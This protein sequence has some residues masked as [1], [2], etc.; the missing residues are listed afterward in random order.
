MCIKTPR[1]LMHPC[2]AS[3]T[4]QRQRLCRCDT[5]HG[6]RV[7]HSLLAVANTVQWSGVSCPE[8]GRVLN[9][10]S[11]L[12]PMSFC[13]AAA[14]PLVIDPRLG[15]ESFRWSGRVGC[16]RCKAAEW[17]WSALV[18]E[19]HRIRTVGGKR[20]TQLLHLPARAPGLEMRD[21]R[22]TLQLP[23]CASEL[24][25]YNFVKRAIFRSG[26]VIASWLDTQAEQVGKARVSSLR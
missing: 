13:Q 3:L 25:S 20:R 24:L 4:L 2:F 14:A 18:G 23:H 16:L 12:I 1:G 17:D 11:C 10:T 9:C 15:V 22:R 8:N 7:E 5:L 6:G 26:S 19:G 21:C